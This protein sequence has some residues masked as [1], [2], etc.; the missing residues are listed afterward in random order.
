MAIVRTTIT[1]P[2]ITSWASLGNS[3]TAVASSA[4]VTVGT[5]TN[6]VD[7]QI[8]LTINGPA[9]MTASSYTV[10]NI[11]VYGSNDGTTW[12]GSNTT[13]ELIDGTD[14]A[15]TLS[16]NGNNA[17]FAG[18]IL[19][20]TTSAGTSVIEYSKVISIAALFGTLPEKYVVVIQ[21]QT[22]AALFASGHAITVIETSYS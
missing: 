9:T 5:S 22:S 18:Q 7:H 17:I 1:A 15:I 11:F 4:A 12:T 16:A 20:P 2:A 8:Q 6:V 10:V 14:K 21:N 19:F 13:N 3:L